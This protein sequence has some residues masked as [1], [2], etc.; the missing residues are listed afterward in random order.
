MCH[1]EWRRL[2]Q[3]NLFLMLVIRNNGFLNF[4]SCS[5]TCVAAGRTNELC[6]FRELKQ[7]VL[8]S[9]VIIRQRVPTDCPLLFASVCVC[10][11]G[12]RSLPLNLIQ[13]SHFVALRF[14]LVPL[15]V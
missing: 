9:A 14:S 13:T 4:L 1:T 3:H 11:R 10:V 15:E 12:E 7:T 8:M 2:N 5:L 6:Y